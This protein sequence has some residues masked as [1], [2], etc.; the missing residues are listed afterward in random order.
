MKSYQKIFFLSPQIATGKSV[1]GAAAHIPHPTSGPKMKMM[2]LFE[3]TSWRLKIE[4][5]VAINYGNAA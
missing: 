5:D 3:D 2:L 1:A 4:E